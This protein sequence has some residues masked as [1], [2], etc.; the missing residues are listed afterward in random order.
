[1]L[2]RRRLAW[3]CWN[4]HQLPD[5][6]GPLALTYNMNLLQGLQA[7]QPLLVTLN[8]SD[9]V[10][11]DSVILSAEYHHP[12]FT[13]ASVVAQARHRDLN[14]YHGTYYCGAWWKNGFHED[15]VVSALTAVKH[16][17]DDCAQRAVHRSA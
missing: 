17:E 13:P 3:A 2:P 9:A 1:L 8:R 11:P 15:G 12:V 5:R 16:F 6:E 14:G 4:Y 7:P 10:D